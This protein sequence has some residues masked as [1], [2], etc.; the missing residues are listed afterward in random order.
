MRNC[1]LQHHV[2]DGTLRDCTS[3][4]KTDTKESKIKT[5]ENVMILKKI[6]H[7]LDIFK[8]LNF[9]VI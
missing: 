6:G 4:E 5:R 8:Y 9:K 1:G 2:E 7:K 3:E